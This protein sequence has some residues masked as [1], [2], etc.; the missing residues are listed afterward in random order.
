MPRIAFKSIF[1]LLA[2]IVA[3]AS[4]GVSGGRAV[5]GPRT[6]TSPVVFIAKDYQFTGPDRIAAGMTT[7]QIV[8]KGQD[9]HHIQLLKLLQG[10]TA[11]DFRAAIAADPT[12]LPTWIKFVGGPNAI[13]PGSE[14][15]AT[16]N[17]AAGDYLLVCLIPDK[18]GVLH[19]ALGM[20][21]PLSVTSAKPTLVSEPKAG[22]TITQADFRFTMSQ[23][24]APGSHT[25]QVMNHGTQ[26][27]EVVV[28][29]LA[30]GASVKDFAAS[31]EPG[32][33]GPPQGRPVGGIVG[34]ESGEHGFFKASFEPGNY[35]LICFFPDP[36]GQPHFVRGMTTEFTVK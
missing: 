20:Q 33:S 36:T 11:A 3:T 13:V 35:G 15:V 18:K 21:R 2:L 6:D 17:L 9:V 27:H 7:I 28:V 24:I 23:P 10:K 14:A 31:V 22:V 5:A 29:K 26:P 12:R 34:L 8:N 25:I 30:P 32:A 16:M 19:V 1:V 4:D